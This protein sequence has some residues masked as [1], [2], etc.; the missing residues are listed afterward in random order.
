M[1]L[2]LGI[3]LERAS[4]ELTFTCSQPQKLVYAFD[5]DNLTMP[6]FLLLAL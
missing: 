5:D 3:G 6:T 1:L 2:V 4:P